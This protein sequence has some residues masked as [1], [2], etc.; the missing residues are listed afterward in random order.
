MAGGKKEKKRGRNVEKELD[1]KTLRKAERYQSN[2][3]QNRQSR[4]AASSCSSN[5]SEQASTSSA[6]PKTPANWPTPKTNLH[7][8]ETTVS[9]YQAA[10]R[11]PATPATTD[12]NLGCSSSEHLSPLPTPVSSSTNL[13]TPSRTYD[14]PQAPP[15]SKTN[16][17][18][19]V[20][21]LKSN[22]QKETISKRDTENPRPLETHGNLESTL[23]RVEKENEKKKTEIA[24][25]QE[26]LEQDLDAL[27]NRELTFHQDMANLDVVLQEISLFKNAKYDKKSDE[28]AAAIP[29]EEHFRQARDYLKKFLHLRNQ[30]LLAFRAV[31]CKLN[32]TSDNYVD[33]LGQYRNRI[34][35]LDCVVQRKGTR[36]LGNRVLRIGTQ[37]L[38]NM[39]QN[40]KDYDD[41]VF[42]D[43]YH[44]RRSTWF[45]KVKHFEGSIK[46]KHELVEKL[47]TI[48]TEKKQRVLEL[49]EELKNMDKEKKESAKALRNAEKSFEESVVN[50]ERYIN[51]VEIGIQKKELALAVSKANQ[52][53]RK[54]IGCL[55][56]RIETYDVENNETAD[57]IKEYKKL[58]E[59]ISLKKKIQEESE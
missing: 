17:K 22:R 14:I 46:F 59:K 51:A 47:K 35:Q 18:R 40:L 29:T 49:R 55:R 5:G 16:L 10:T 24:M 50:D 21:K 45:K 4:E 12:A 9:C 48:L 58:Q 54:R 8:I 36:C 37:L 23:E 42:G 57:I 33:L 32:N 56:N 43:T 38:Q 53:V 27:T 28:N 31:E 25:K 2:A 20:D 34:D 44:C 13:A 6:K 1:T 7:E 3:Q 30:K 39:Y 26:K 41:R 52:D 15:I 19:A 11:T